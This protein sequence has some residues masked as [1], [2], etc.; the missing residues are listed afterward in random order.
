MKTMVLRDPSRQITEITH[1]HKT[2]KPNKKGAFEVDD[3]HVEALRSHGL[4]LE[5]EVE[6]EA[7]QAIADK[8]K[9]IADQGKV[10]EDLTGKLAALTERLEKLE[11]KS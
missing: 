6:P 1:E 7:K 2:Y 10:I 11:K 9:V 5:G 4:K 3:G 8:D